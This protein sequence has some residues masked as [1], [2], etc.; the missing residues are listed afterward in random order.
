[1]LLVI[2]A[3]FPVKQRCGNPRYTCA[4]APD[5][6]G[7]VHYYYAVVPL[8]I[9]FVESVT[10]LEFPSIHYSTGEELVKVR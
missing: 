6:Q 8:G 5:A 7:N 2:V 3:A 10:T 9:D 4:T 1:V